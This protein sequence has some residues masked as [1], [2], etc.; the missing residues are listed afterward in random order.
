VDAHQN[1]EDF[2]VVTR[3]PQNGDSQHWII[4]PA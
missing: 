2:G 1:G 3:P 4:T